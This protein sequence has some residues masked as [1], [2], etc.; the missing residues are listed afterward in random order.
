MLICVHVY[1]YIYSMMCFM[2]VCF[3]DAYYINIDKSVSTSKCAHMFY[4]GQFLFL[5][6][7]FGHGIMWYEVDNTHSA[8]QFPALSIWALCNI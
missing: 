7:Y 6:K 1:A 4:I 8:T 5:K 2:Y 3:W